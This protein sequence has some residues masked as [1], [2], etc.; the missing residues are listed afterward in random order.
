MMAV[1]TVAIEHCPSCGSSE[2]R[3]L[4][5]GSDRLHGLP[6]TFPVMLCAACHSAY[7]AQRPLE[8]DAYYPVES[9]AAYDHANTGQHYSRGVWRNYGLRQRR[10]L[11][12]H[13]KPAGGYLL[14]VGCG[15][16]DFLA[17]MQAEG[18]WQVSG[19]E[20]N[21]AAGRYARE[22]RG[23]DVRI[24]RLPDQ[25]L[26]TQIFDVITMWH[27]L[28]HVPD[29]AAV[30]AEVRRLLKP[31]GVLIVAVPLS[32]SVEAVWFK[33]NWAGYD[34]PRHLVTFTRVSLSQ[35]ALRQGFRF[36]EQRGIV[37]GISSLRISL[38][39]WLGQRGGAWRRLR[40]LWLMLLL[41]P[42]YLIL[43][44]RSGSRL[45]VGVFVGRVV[46]SCYS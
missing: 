3:F 35:F 2:R 45:S 32:D 11:L 34:V 17:L 36:E 15:S 31:E 13:L 23:L 43:R 14:D 22:T 1:T 40:R 20:P 26:P 5:D 41:P 44:L 18:R 19:L 8:L 21:A 25:A 10:R 7:L 30:L 46:D 33:A 4:F 38:G 24:G 9:Y 12:D 37:Q 6:G 42:L 29:P 16:G 39:M 27:V 28:E